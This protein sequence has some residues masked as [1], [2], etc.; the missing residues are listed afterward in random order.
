MDYYGL[1]LLLLFFFYISVSQHASVSHKS[2]LMVSACTVLYMP[3]PTPTLDIAETCQLAVLWVNRAYDD[4][5][6]QG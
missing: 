3:P 2:A 6:T 5:G 4:G 1:F